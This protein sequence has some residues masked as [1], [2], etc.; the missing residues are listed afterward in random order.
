MCHLREQKI[1][2]W[3]RKVMEVPEDRDDKRKEKKKQAVSN[4]VKKV[5]IL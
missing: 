2:F 5:I 1:L 4:M 3:P